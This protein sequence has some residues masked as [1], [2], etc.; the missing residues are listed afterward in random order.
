L[1][2]IFASNLNQIRLLDAGSLIP[3]KPA[4]NMTPPF[5][6]SY[7]P[8][9]YFE[10]YKQGRMMYP[11]PGYVMYA[12]GK[13]LWEILTNKQPYPGEHPNF[14]EPV[15]QNYSPDL[16]NLINHLLQNRY[17]SFERLKQSLN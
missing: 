12:V 15:L 10:A 17:S 5:T 3:L 16:K 8:V 1:N 11:T 4:S 13:M 2:F 7:I 6:E 9:E 14:S